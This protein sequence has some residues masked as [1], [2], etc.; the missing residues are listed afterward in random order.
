MMKPPLCPYRLK[1]QAQCQIPNQPRAGK[2]MVSKAF[3][4]GQA[5]GMWPIGAMAE[6]KTAI[7]AGIEYL[8]K[9]ICRYVTISVLLIQSD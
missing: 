6:S 2:A 1:P 5:A 8:P 7:G 9:I 3:N 4:R